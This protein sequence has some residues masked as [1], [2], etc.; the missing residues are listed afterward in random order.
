MELTSFPARP[1][2]EDHGVDCTLGNYRRTLPG[3][4][5]Q[6]SLRRKQMQFRVWGTTLAQSCLPLALQS[7][8]AF[9]ALQGRQETED[10]SNATVN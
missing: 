8:E 9:H 5:L 1:A 3:S 6:L 7:F 4:D 10:V 2:L